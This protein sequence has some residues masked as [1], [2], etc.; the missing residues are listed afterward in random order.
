MK[1]DLFP[2]QHLQVKSPQII[3]ARRFLKKALQLRD[4]RGV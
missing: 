4:G 3:A 1:E 2:P